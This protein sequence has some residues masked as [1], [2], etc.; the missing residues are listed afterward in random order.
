MISIEGLLSSTQ[1]NLPVNDRP[2]KR[3]EPVNPLVVRDGN[4]ASQLF[5]EVGAGSP[6]D[7]VGTSSGSAPGMALVQALSIARL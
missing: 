6:E 1:M 2:T 7:R 3:V 4:K 5:W